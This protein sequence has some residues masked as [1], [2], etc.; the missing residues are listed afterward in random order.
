MFRFTDLKSKQLK[1]KLS[2]KD[3]I[4]ICLMGEWNVLNDIMP[5]HF[6]L[7]LLC[8]FFFLA[9]NSE[10]DQEI[11]QSQTADNPVAPRVKSKLR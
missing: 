5:K 3:K 10:Y 6:L 9:K 2:L 4:V 1:L 11:P 7:C 8:K